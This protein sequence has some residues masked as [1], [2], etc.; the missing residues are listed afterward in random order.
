VA[1]LGRFPLPIE[2]T[3]FGLGATRRAVEAAAAATGCHSDI[4]L[5]TD[6]NG[7][8]VLTDGGHWLLDGF[9]GTIRDAEGLAVRLQAIPG[10]MEHGLFLGLANAVIVA[11][12][13]GL[14]I[15]GQL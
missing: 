8:P 4:R 12:P 3:P 11:G 7:E 13:S 14:A 9:F 6:M 10:V 5:R 15:H 2:V 1:T